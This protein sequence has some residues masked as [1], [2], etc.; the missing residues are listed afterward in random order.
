MA[1][2]G[3]QIDPQGALALA[4]RAKKKEIQ[5]K[6]HPVGKQHTEQLRDVRDMIIVLFDKISDI[7][8]RLLDMEKRSTP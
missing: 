3:G 5:E 4:K 8:S 6:L 7:E 1:R 2:V